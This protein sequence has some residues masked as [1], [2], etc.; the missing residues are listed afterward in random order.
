MRIR[1]VSRVLSVKNMDESKDDSTELFGAARFLPWEECFLFLSIFCNF[2][3]RHNLSVSV[4][5]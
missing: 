1:I 5:S 4:N 2:L 3:R